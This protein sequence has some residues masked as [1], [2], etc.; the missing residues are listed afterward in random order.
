MLPSAESATL[1]PKRPAPASSFGRS[2]ACGVQDEPERVYT[3]AAP[4]AVA[5]SLPPTIA[6]VPSAERATLRPNWAGS[7]SPLVSLP[8]SWLQ[9]PPERTNVHAAPFFPSS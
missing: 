8:P 7:S 3:H 2:F 9:T 6:V 5:Y 4:F 1:V